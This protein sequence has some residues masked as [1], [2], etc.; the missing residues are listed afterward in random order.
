MKKDV[1]QGEED[2]KFIK[3][4]DKKTS[5]Y[6]FQNNKITIAAFAIVTIILILLLI[7][8]F[9]TSTAI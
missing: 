8:V 3:D 1:K 9:S 2:I 7:A 4:K 6:F 5:N